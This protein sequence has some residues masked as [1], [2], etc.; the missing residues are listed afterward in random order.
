MTVALKVS[1]AFRHKARSSSTDR[2]IVSSTSS[3]VAVNGTP[4]I[5]SRAVR[6]NK[7]NCGAN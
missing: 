4:A 5:A 6:E 1:R 2:A 7:T 3:D